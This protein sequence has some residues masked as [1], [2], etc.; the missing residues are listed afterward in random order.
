M[1]TDEL[2]KWIRY[3]METN[4]MYIFYHSK[5]WKNLKEEILRADHYECQRCKEEGRLTLLNDGSPVHHVNEVKKAPHL[6]LSKY[7]YDKNGIKQRQL[8]S[9][10]FDCHNIIHDRFNKSNKFMNEERW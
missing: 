10:C 6:A 7:Y 4:K 1:D 8:I 2:V 9:L 5:Y 3:L